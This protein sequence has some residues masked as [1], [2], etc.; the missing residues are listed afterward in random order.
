LGAIVGEATSQKNKVMEQVPGRLKI[1]KG[2]FVNDVLL[3]HFKKS[4]GGPR[5]KIPRNCAIL[6]GVFRPNRNVIETK[7]GSSKKAK[8]VIQ[9]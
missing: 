6:G 3:G 7:G 4:G 2:S 5:K 1:G 9:G 8:R